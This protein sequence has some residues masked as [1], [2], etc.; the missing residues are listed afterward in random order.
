M[1]AAGFLRLTAERD[2]RRLLRDPWKLGLWLCVPLLIGVLMTSV[3]GG[4]GGMKP[5]A[6]L[7]IEDQDDTFL[8]GLLVNVFS[9]D[10]MS[11]LVLIEHLDGEAA[12]ERLND[13][14]G[15]AFLRIPEGFGDAVLDETP[16][17]LELV[18]NPA[19]SILP[20]ILE[21]TLSILRDAV[22]YIHRLFGPQ[23][24]IM[25]E[26]PEPDEFTLADPV[27]AALSVGINKIAQDVSDYVDPLRLE[28]TTVVDSVE[29]ESDEEGLELEFSFFMFPSMLLM[30]MFFIAQGM[31]EDY[32]QEREQGTL[33]RYLYGP[34]RLRL[35]LGG[36]LL[37]ALVLFLIIGVILFSIGYA[38]HGLRWST[39]PAAV[40]WWSLG[41]LGVYAL[42][43][44]VQLWAS[45]RRAGSI[46]TNTAMFPLLMLGG[47]F[48]PFEAMPDWMVAVGRWT[49]NG[50]ILSELKPVLMDEADYAALAVNAVLLVLVTGALCW[51]VLRRLRKVAALP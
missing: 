17:T 51:L 43:S 9:S 23:L 15:T 11:E 19:Q 45:T 4:A 3:M 27:V 8:S 49:P 28:L 10:Q 2:L 47:S 33:R 37:A 25:R 48:F 39:L 22:F 32:W 1:R 34:R 44:L 5:Q 16:V 13:N 18:T 21:E 7:F 29:D 20:G 24:A 36:K 12:L 42:V 31:S 41:G 40:L 30:A 35:L 38:Y 14:D 46:L 26:G 6:L 50:W